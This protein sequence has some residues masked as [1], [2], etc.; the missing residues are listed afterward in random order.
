MKRLRPATGSIEATRA[1]ADTEP[2]R[3]L[4]RDRSGALRKRRSGR[5]GAVLMALVL[6]MSL[7]GGSAYG[8]RH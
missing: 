3:I 1:G 6:G 5:G 8:V 4:R 2:L 7:L